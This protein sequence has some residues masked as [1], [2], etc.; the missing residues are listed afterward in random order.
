MDSA[1]DDMI[2]K[3]INLGL[4]MHTRSE[5]VRLRL[6]GL[7]CSEKLWRAH[8]NKLLGEHIDIGAFIGQSLTRYGY[9]RVCS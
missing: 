3:A 1:T 5:D 8:G 7:S 4:L 9:H 6:F 2:L